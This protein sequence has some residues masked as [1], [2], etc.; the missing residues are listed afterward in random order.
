MDGERE[1]RE[2]MGRPN[3]RNVLTRHADSYNL[4]VYSP[5]GA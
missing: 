5:D 1:M 2:L 3:Q 4:H